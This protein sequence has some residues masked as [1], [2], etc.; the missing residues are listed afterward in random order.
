MTPWIPWETTT[1]E[2]SCFRAS[3]SVGK[4]GMKARK[5][6][7][8]S[9]E[10]LATIPKEQR[11]FEIDLDNSLQATKTLGV[12][13]CAQQDVFSFQVKKPTEEANLKKWIILSKVAGVF[14]PLGLAS[15]FTVRG[16]ILFQDETKG[17]GWDK[18]I[19]HQFSNRARDWFSELET[20]KETTTPRCNSWH[21]VPVKL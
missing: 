7:S 2:F 15:P 1:A 12:L 13:W 5:W 10:V 17:L 6:L 16:K 19:D 9:P 3:R 14:D 21:I 4:A 11:A 8:N 18:P 20:L